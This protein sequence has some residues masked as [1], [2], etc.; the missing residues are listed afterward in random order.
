M[1]AVERL[2]RWTTA[3]ADLGV[4]AVAAVASH[5]HA[6]ALVRVHGEAGGT[7]TDPAEVDGLIC[8]RSMMMLDSARLKA[9]AGA[10][11][12]EAWGI[13]ATLAA[14]VTHGPWR[15]RSRGA[16]MAGG[17]PGRGRTNSSWSSAPPSSRRLY[18]GRLLHAGYRS[19][20]GAGCEGVRW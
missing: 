14:N 13:A 15:G 5:D 4:A 19:A 7:T 20:A 9:R 3:G 18:G 16:C 17:G 6:C 8:A 11:A 2:I 1:M 10:V 12:A